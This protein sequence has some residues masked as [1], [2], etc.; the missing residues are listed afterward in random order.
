[1]GR[2]SYN[3]QFL[4][5][6]N[7]TIYEHMCKAEENVYLNAYETS[8]ALRVVL[9]KL[10]EGI[11]IRDSVNKAEI[12]ISQKKYLN[13]D[14]KK[15]LSLFENIRVIE[16]V[17]RRNRDNPNGLSRMRILPEVSFGRVK[18]MEKKSYSRVDFVRI[19]ANNG[20]HDIEKEKIRA[21]PNN[22]IIA[23]ESMHMILVEYCRT[24]GYSVPD[25]FDSSKLPIGKY[26]VDRKYTPVD[27]VW[28]KCKRE[29]YC[30]F[31]TG[32]NHKKKQ[33]AILREYKRSDFA[34]DRNFIARNNDI[35]GELI[36]NSGAT[37]ARVCELNDFSRDVNSS[38]FIVYEF[39]CEPF[40]LGSKFFK[41][42]DLSIKDRLLICTNLINSVQK[43]HNSNPPIYHRD[44]T[45]DSIMMCDYSGNNQGWIPIITKFN[46]AKM[47]ADD[48]G[49]VIGNL[50]AAEDLQDEKNAFMK[51]TK[52]KI[53]EINEDTDWAKF[54]IYSL[55]T[56]IVD[57]LSQNILTNKVTPEQLDEIGSALFLKPDSKTLATLEGMI[58]EAVFRRPCIDDVKIVFDKELARWL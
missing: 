49:T 31:Y 45:Y 55:G 42:H 53:D 30:H 39:S 1:M 50:K 18:S 36:L 38:Y 43:L 4:A 56:L 9:T 24:C 17:F 29:Y 21:N 6:F 13:G 41:K 48:V 10:V 27:T 47:D 28:S 22:A 20:P 7:E 2:F 54:D 8:Q 52:Y 26:Y 51:M 11:I 25:R 3:N 58:S 35:Y 37:L 32:S 5:E 33:Y 19:F 34:E 15:E 23:I 16:D 40:P 57:I 12:S 46:F 14:T 44:L